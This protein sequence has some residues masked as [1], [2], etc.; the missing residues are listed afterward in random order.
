MQMGTMI[1]KCKC[2]MHSHLFQEI[3]SMSMRKREEQSSSMVQHSL[4]LPCHSP[5]FVLD[6]RND[7]CSSLKPYKKERSICPGMSPSQLWSNSF[8]TR[9]H[10]HHTAAKPH[11]SRTMEFKERKFWH[12]KKSS[13]H[14]HNLNLGYAVVF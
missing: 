11:T 4:L 2:K 12:S 5:E 13:S 3:K 6:C 9:S 14:Q 7:F 8:S 1:S 10:N